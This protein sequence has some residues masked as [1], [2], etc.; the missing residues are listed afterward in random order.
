[1][2][3]LQRAA[4]ARELVGLRGPAAVARDEVEQAREAAALLTAINS[5]AAASTPTERFAQRLRQA[6]A[7]SDAEQAS[8][9]ARAAVNAAVSATKE[10]ARV[11]RLSQQ[12]QQ[13]QQQ[14]QQQQGAGVPSET[15]DGAEPPPSSFDG[16]AD[17][18]EAE[19]LESSLEAALATQGNGLVR[20]STRTEA[21]VLSRLDPR[22]S[23]VA[24]RGRSA[25][26]R[27]V[28]AQFGLVS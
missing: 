19:E 18:A 17:A 10:A 13:P 16:A 27:P 23:P 2:S 11:L 28:C 26:V 25:W 7:A 21:R 5:E 24:P 14:Q 20:P 15:S 3:T 6:K 1:M 22:V 9:R 4:Y 12:Q 8:N